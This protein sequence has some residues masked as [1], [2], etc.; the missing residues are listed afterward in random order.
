MLISLDEPLASVLVERGLI[1]EKMEKFDLAFHPLL[2]ILPLCL[3]LLPS[4]L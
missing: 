4:L 3:V 1:Y 2:L